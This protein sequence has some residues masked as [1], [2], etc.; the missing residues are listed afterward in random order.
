M[1]NV[2]R[3]SI[4]TFSF[5]LVLAGSPTHTF[6]RQ[7][8]QTAFSPSPKTTALI[9]RNIGQAEN[10]V[11]IAAYSFTSQ[12]VADALISAHEKGVDVKAVVDKTQ[13]NPRSHSIVAQ[14]AAAGIAVRVNR[15]HSIMHNKYMVIDGRTIQTGSFNYTANAEKRNAENIMVIRNNPSLAKTYLANWQTLWDE[16]EDYVANDNSPI[17]LAPED[18]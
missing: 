8:T 12:P 16:S 17:K 10:V 18:K 7:Y 4:A 11:R 14:L 2:F 9:T 13:A 5:I 1:K 3:N 6:A 15:K